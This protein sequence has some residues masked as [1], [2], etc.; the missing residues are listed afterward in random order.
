MWLNRLL[1]I[2]LCVKSIDY[3]NYDGKL[4]EILM[5]ITLVA[6]EIKYAQCE[7]LS[8]LSCVCVRAR[9]R[10]RACVRACWN[11]FGLHVVEAGRLKEEK[12]L[13]LNSREVA[14]S[15]RKSCLPRQ[16]YTVRPVGGRTKI[17]QN[18]QERCKKPQVQCNNLLIYLCREV[19]RPFD[20]FRGN[21]R[22]ALS[23]KRNWP[24]ST[25]VTN[26]TSVHKG[27]AIWAFTISGRRM[28]VTARE[29]IRVLKSAEPWRGKLA[30]YP[31]QA[32]IQTKPPT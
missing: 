16:F 2:I 12:N 11:G 21:F 24:W 4:S 3:V 29:P 17:P 32:E 28:H 9:A 10:V 26:Y 5:N 25:S 31:D 6:L 15:V 20:L 30:L 19:W 18:A 13:W 14:P 27:W 22:T 23:H 8:L 1:G 7:F